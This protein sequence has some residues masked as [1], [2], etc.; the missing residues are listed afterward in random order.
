M[1]R[2]GLPPDATIID[3]DATHLVTPHI[4]DLVNP[5]PSPVTTIAGISGV[6]HVQIHFV[7]QDTVS[8]VT[9]FMDQIGSLCVP[10]ALDVLVPVRTILKSFGDDV[11]MSVLHCRHFSS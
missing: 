10:R 5:I 2:P 4:S 9:G 11:A 6:K 7:I 8:M 3:G 1:A